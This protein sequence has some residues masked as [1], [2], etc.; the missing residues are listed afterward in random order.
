[1]ITNRRIKNVKMAR[2]YLYALRLC[3]SL[4]FFGR[5]DLTDFYDVWHPS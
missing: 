4:A 1:M 2:T 5:I 3:F